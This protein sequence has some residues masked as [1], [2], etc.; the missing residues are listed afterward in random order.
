MISNNALSFPW[1]QQGTSSCRQ[2]LDS[3]GRL[4]INWYQNDL[5]LDRAPILLASCCRLCCKLAPQ[6]LEDRLRLAWT[7]L[8]YENPAIVGANAAA[9][10]AGSPMA[11]F[12]CV[13][14]A[15]DSQSYKKGPIWVAKIAADITL[16]NI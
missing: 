9:C 16:V 3:F 10:R 11:C 6:D 7:A 12:E 15:R 13:M 8:R 14:E 4:W 5:Q 2:K 1:V